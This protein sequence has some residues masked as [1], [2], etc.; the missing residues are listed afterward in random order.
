MN[1]NTGVARRYLPKHDADR[2]R[3]EHRPR[4][5]RVQTKDLLPVNEQSHLKNGRRPPEDGERDN[6]GGQSRIVVRHPRRTAKVA[7]RIDCVEGAATFFR[8]TDSVAEKQSEHGKTEETRHLR[9]A[10]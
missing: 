10:W 5:H 3:A 1:P 2:R 9:E 4:P 6:H 8:G 7:N